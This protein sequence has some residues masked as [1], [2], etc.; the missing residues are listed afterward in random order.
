MLI[1]LSE[2]F[3]DEPPYLSATLLV[4]FDDRIARSVQ[5]RELTLIISSFHQL[6]PGNQLK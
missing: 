2:P 6:C 1:Q 3:F 4:I 5:P